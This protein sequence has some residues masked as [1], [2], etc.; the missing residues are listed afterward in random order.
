MVAIV[1]HPKTRELV[2]Q[3]VCDICH[4]DPGHRTRV[5]KGH[6]FRRQDAPK[7]IALAGADTIRA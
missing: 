2:A 3:P 7:A 6:F 1:R 5:I 4:Y